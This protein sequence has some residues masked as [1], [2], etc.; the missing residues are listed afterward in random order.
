MNHPTADRC[1]EDGFVAIIVILLMIPLLLIVGTFLHTMTGRNSRLRVEVSE[2]QALCAAEAGVD[3]A[4]H[5]ARIAAL[6][7]GMTLTE[8]LPRGSMFEAVISH[9][10]SDGLDNNSDG[11]VDE[12]DEDVYRV[13][14]TGRH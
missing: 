8:V 10:G 9:F 4:L 14:S 6:D 12:I 1:K 13:V 2:E 11:A 3:V 7:D 5:R